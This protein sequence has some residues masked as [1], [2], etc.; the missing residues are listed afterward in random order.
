MKYINRAIAVIS[1]A[2]ILAFMIIVLILA[3]LSSLIRYYTPLIEDYKEPI[4]D[5][6]NAVS[7]SFHVTAQSIKCEW[8]PLQPIFILEDVELEI[9]GQ[10]EDIK[11][12]KLRLGVD[13]FLT[14]YYRNL[15]FEEV[16]LYSLDLVLRQ[17]E[18]GLWGLKRTA[19]KTSKETSSNKS[20]RNTVLSFWRD[21]NLILDELDIVLE[22]YGF[23]PIQMPKA[24]VASAR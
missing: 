21:N 15:Y 5:R 4:L 14:L 9:A 3:L 11:L 19:E 18:N 22:P 8:Q 16:E 24:K 7:D 20:L 17:S 23:Q 13:L 10:D 2:I 6:I 12:K 1:K